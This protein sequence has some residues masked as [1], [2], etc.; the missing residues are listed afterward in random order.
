MVTWTRHNVTTCALCLSCYNL[1][2]IFCML[3]V[4]FTNGCTGHRIGSCC[5]T[6]LPNVLQL[7]IINSSLHLL[8]KTCV[9]SLM[10]NGDWANTSTWGL[11]NRPCWVCKITWKAEAS[12]NVMTH[13]QKPDFVF[14]RN[15]RVHLNRPAGASVQST[16]GSRC[17]RISGS[18]AG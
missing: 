17:V 6:V 4:C 13:A 5:S 10:N 8:V 2:L 15:G 1:M 14:R 7:L 3:M 9:F 11:A 12:W 18:N 16:T